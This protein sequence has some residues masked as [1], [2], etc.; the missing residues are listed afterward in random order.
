MATSNSLTEQSSFRDHVFSLHKQTIRN[1]REQ[2]NGAA[3]QEWNKRIF[4]ISN[5]QIHIHFILSFFVKVKCW[6]FDSQFD[7]HQ[8]SIKKLLFLFYVKK[9]FRIKK[10]RRQKTGDVVDKSGTRFVLRWDNMLVSLKWTWYL[11]LLQKH[12]YCHVIVEI[13]I[14]H[15]QTFVALVQG[16]VTYR[17]SYAMR[18]NDTRGW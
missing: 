6:Y 16:W 5:L 11:W 18:H 15:L 17:F 4:K 14:I 1:L 9:Y 2:L 12:N 8:T 10:R 13:C 3:K 7:Q